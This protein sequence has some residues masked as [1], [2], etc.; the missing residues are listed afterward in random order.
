MYICR[1]CWIYFRKCYFVCFD[2][3]WHCWHH[4]FNAG[5]I[6]LFSLFPP[7]SLIKGTLTTF[8]TATERKAR[9]QTTHLT[10]AWRSSSPIHQ[11]KGIITVSA[12]SDM[13]VMHRHPGALQG[14]AQQTLHY[15]RE[16]ACGFLSVIRTSQRSTGCY[17]LFY[18]WAGPVR[19]RG[20]SVFHF[21]LSQALQAYSFFTCCSPSSACGLDSWSKLFKV[22]CLK[23]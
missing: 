16:W 5:L 13:S 18:Y 7:I 2:S 6:C 21:V 11:A 1:E 12:F 10:A 15:Y 19:E 8:V 14:T 23:F 22:E 20:P 3:S 4:Q 9:G 17:S